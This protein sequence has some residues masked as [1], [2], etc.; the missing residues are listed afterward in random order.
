[1]GKCPFECVA[2]G[3]EVLLFARERR[4]TRSAGHTPGRPR[5]SKPPVINWDGE[6]RAPTGK[7][8]WSNPEIDVIDICTPNDSHREIAIEAA[9][10]G[11]AF[12]A[13]SRSAM[14]VAECEEM[15]EAVKKAKV[16][17][18]SATLP[19]HS[20]AIALA[21]RMIENGDLGDRI[22]HYRARY[23]QDWIRRSQLPAR[24]APP[25]EKLPVPAPMA[26]STPTS[27]TWAVIWSGKSRKSAA[28]WKR[29]SRNALCSR[30]R[31]PARRQSREET[32]KVTVDDA[33]S[34]IGRFK[35]G[36]VANLEATRFAH[37]R[38]NH[39]TLEVN[40]SKGSSLS[41]SRI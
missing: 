6:R 1:M 20:S 14:N 9:R 24:L 12:S 21:K 33:V 23:A 39:I 35:N 34:L 25:G 13:K 30:K 38:K 26:T 8:W 15:V 18:W 19:P 31:R 22:Y 27:S 4:C 16:V 36:A 32:G 3:P 11:K 2:P 37:G 10:H 40:G 5:A 7:R 17:T 28:S 29:S 41:I